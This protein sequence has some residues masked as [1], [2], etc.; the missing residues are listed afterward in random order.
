MKIVA[1]A[2]STSSQ[3]INKHLVTYAGQL[4][5]AANEGSAVEVL[6]LNDYALPM[7]SEDEEKRS[8]RPAAA[9][10]FYDK[11]GAADVLLISFAEH[12]GSYAAA[13]KNL[14]DWMSRIDSKVFQGKPAVFLAASPGPSG[15]QSV[16]KAAEASAPYFGAEVKGSL[17]VPGFYDVFDKQ[18]QKLTDESLNEQLKSA[19]A[20]LNG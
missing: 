11:L 15:A 7:F 14:F 17:S 19:L 12:N 1:F 2:A 8:G 4:L 5:A 6:D 10:S 20:K 9:Q 13:Y 16:L 18:A 3:S